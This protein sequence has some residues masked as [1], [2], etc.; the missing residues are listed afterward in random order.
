MF[1][2]SF[3]KGLLYATV[4]LEYENKIVAVNDVIIDTGASHTIILTDYLEYLD[5]PLFDDDELVK[6]SGYGGVQFSAIR[7]KIKKVSVGDI[8]IDD[9][10]I[11]FGLID[12]Y[13]RVNGLIGLDF[14]L[15]AGVIIDLSNLSVYQNK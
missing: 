9:M 4:E 1:S 2:M 8:S 15:N 11:D 10:K 12:P 14:L 7:K 13:E 3:K 5:I 6:S